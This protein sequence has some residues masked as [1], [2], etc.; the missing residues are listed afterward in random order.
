M[1]YNLFESII[2]CTSNNVTRENANVNADVPAGIMMKVASETSKE[3]AHDYLLSD[4]ARNAVDNNVIWVH[5]LDYYPTKSTTCV[6]HP[7][8]KILEGGFQA[9]DGTAR[10]CKRIETAGAL[11]AIAMQTVQNE[12]H[13]GQS[14][15]AFDFYMAPYVRATYK[16]EIYKLKDF[17]SK[18]GYNEQDLKYFCDV[19]FCDYNLPVLGYGEPI[20]NPALKN[21]VKRVH[22]AMEAFIH[23]MN[24]MRS[25]GGGQT[26]FSS[27]NYGTDTSAEGRC[28][29]RELL[30]S[31][32]EG[33]GNGQTA[34]FPIQI[35]K[36][37]KGV[38][39]EPG[40]TNYD[41]LQLACEVTAKRF[42]PNFI[43]LDATFNQCDLWDINDPKRYRFEVATMGCRT[44]VFENRFS[45]PTSIGRGNLSF[46]TVNLPR[47]ALMSGGNYAKFLELLEE[48]VDIA[49]RQLYDRFSFQCTALK[50]QFPMLMNGVWMDSDKL[51]NPDTVVADVLKHGTLSVGFIGLAE[52]LIVLTGHHHGEDYKSQLL[53]LKIIGEMR[54]R[55]NYWSDKLNLNVSLLATP[56]E[57]LAGRFVIK[58]RKDFGVIENVTDRDYYTNS[59]HVP[60]WYKC[61]MEEKAQIE[62]PYHALTNAGHIFYVEFDG[63]AARN[64]ESVM[65]FVNLIRKYNIGYA[66]VNHTRSRC[67]DCGYENADADLKVCPDCGSENIDTIQRITGYLVGCTSRWNKGK[68]AELHDRVTHTN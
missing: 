5:D 56:A 2:N 38:S 43:N 59:N 52:T 15:P 46:T 20:I 53:G 33:V 68:L 7:L 10:P 14:I 51:Q 40:D 45:E 16:E 9:S 30:K 17:A 36:L 19:E 48:T 66:S 34:I 35:W 22:Q 37:K 50:K 1:D 27:I 54:D 24:T 25:R 11:A 65:D 28:V 32:Y 60:V 62:A 29:I 18:Y 42:F 58:D 57:S 8:D 26:V 47:I 49:V 23:N 3:F 63:D 13:G 64:P 39:A 6:Q 55:C 4:E 67:L 61:T 41:L 44:R 12:Q 31:T 21:T